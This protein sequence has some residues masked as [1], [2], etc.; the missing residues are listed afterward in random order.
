MTGTI[1]KVDV[2]LLTP[3]ASCHFTGPADLRRLGEGDFAPRAAHVNFSEGA[4]THWHSHSGVQ[5]LLFI[6][7]EGE[8]STE[9]KTLACHVGDLVRVDAHVKHRHGAAANETT[10]HL[11]ITEGETDWHEDC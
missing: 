1:E 2:S 8:V 4:Q 10:A 7:G 5:W 11:A 3:E 6:N 9:E